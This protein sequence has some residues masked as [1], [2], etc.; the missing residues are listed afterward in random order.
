MPAAVIAT[1]Q[2]LRITVG[3]KRGGGWE[4][5]G[6]GDPRPVKTQGAGIAEGTKVLNASSGG[7]ELVIKGRDGKIR[8][9][10]TINRADPRKSKG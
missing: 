1:N 4:L 3:P 6:N 5:T 10:R 2:K 7:G 9:T 8:D